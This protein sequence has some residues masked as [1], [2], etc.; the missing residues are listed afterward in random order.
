MLT[1]PD[2][3]T[4]DTWELNY[5]NAQIREYQTEQPDKLCDG[6]LS[7]QPHINSN[8]NL[9]KKAYGNP[10]PTRPRDRLNRLQFKLEQMTARY[11]QC[12]NELKAEY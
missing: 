12:E 10:R 8:R 1:R 2:P 6:L 9:T 7:R 5:E 11:K 3:L 4:A